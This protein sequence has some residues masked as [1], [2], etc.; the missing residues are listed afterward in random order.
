M[1]AY[2]RGLFF[3]CCMGLA[4]GALAQAITVSPGSLDSATRSQLISPHSFY[5]NGPLSE[6]LTT[7]IAGHMY[8]AGPTGRTLLTL[9]ALRMNAADIISL[10][11]T[12]AL[13]LPDILDNNPFRVSLTAR[14]LLTETAGFAVPPLITGTVPLRRYITHVRTAGQMAHADTVG[15]ALLVKYLEVRGGAPILTLFQTH[16]LDALKLPADA[17]EAEISSGAL[18]FVN[19]LKASGKLL[20]E[21]AR[22]MVRNRD[23]NGARFLPADIY[24][25]VTARHNWR[26]HPIGPRRT[27]GGVIHTDDG[28]SWIS[29]PALPKNNSGPDFMA[30]PAEGIVFV[31]L[32]GITA[33]FQT[34]V[35]KLAQERFL[36][37]APDTRLREAQGIYD[38]G[39]RFSG[40]YVSSNTPSA[41]LADRL[42][43]VEAHTIN[44]TDPGDGTLHVSGLPGTGSAAL[45]YHKKAPFYFEAVGDSHMT[46]SPYRQGGYLVLDGML[47]RYSGILGNQ[48]FVVLAFPYVA[49]FLLSSGLYMRSNTSNRWRKMGQFGTV[50]TLMISAGAACEFFLWPQA[51]FTW[52][53]PF[54]VNLWRFAINAGLAFILSL[55]IFALAFTTG[56]E[57]PKDSGILYV[58]L[59]LALL[60]IAAV[61]LFLITVAWGIAGEFSAY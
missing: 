43:A 24:E 19:S 9:L 50:G 46:L 48:T 30:F 56:G 13:D 44:L 36:P 34:S 39:M 60:C 52:D 61:A 20:A 10:D 27:L 28:H 23:A 31:N 32:R 41:W 21:T 25:Q 37:G 11:D 14:H 42:R 53:M 18:I 40:N 7:E 59:H 54:L 57:M 22:L 55:P 16:V 51:I 35:L 8:P 3:L 47:F 4:E 6:G 33:E 17:L 49:I 29:A 58:P 38:K 26:M 2:V 15:W 12:I 45:V 5:V 1:L